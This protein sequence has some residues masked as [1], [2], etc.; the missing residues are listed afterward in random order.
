MP[1]TAQ[2][3]GSPKLSDLF[4]C[5]AEA[6]KAEQE[7]ILAYTRAK[8][9]QREATKAA[10]LAEKKWQEAAK[11]RSEIGREYLHALAA[12]RGEVYDEIRCEFVR[13]PA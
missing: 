10:N 9:T 5:G 8:A 3:S 11:K 6:L 7:A 1:I 12:E 13:R 2:V 4:L